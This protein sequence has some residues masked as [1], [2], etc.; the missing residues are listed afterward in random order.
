M[1]K[2]SQVL[3]NAANNTT[4]AGDR[5]TLNRTILSVNKIRQQKI[6][7]FLYDAQSIKSAE[8]IGDEFN[9]KTWF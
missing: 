1:A 7:R 3:Y 2:S 8:F 4:K 9:S 5:Q 6:G